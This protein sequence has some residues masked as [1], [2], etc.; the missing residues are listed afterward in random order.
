MT[1][2]EE[3]KRLYYKTT[4]TTVQRD[5]ERAIDLLKAM[6]T[7]EERERASVYMEGLAEMRKEWARGSTAG[8][9]RR[10]RG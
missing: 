1:P 3:I 8:A 6:E 7:D 4:R 5:F 2:F 10:R 9:P